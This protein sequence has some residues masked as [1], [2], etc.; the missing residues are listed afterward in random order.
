MADPTNGQP[1]PTNGN[2]NYQRWQNVSQFVHKLN[3]LQFYVT[4]SLMFYSA[5]MVWVGTHLP[6]TTSMESFLAL[7]GVINAGLVP[8]VAFWFSNDQKK[9]ELEAKGNNP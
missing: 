8:I 5:F 7:V 9:R 1:T 2:G 3:S 4:I 6:P